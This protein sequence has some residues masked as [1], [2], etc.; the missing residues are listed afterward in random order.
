M[1]NNNRSLSNG[2]QIADI[3][4][5]DLNGRL[6]NNLEESKITPID[7]KKSKEA[8]TTTESKELYIPPTYIPSTEIC[9]PDH[10]LLLKKV[11]ERKD[12][13][14]INI[15]IDSSLSVEEMFQLYNNEYSH[16]LVNGSNAIVRK[17]VNDFGEIDYEY[18]ALEQFRSATR[19]HPKVEINGKK[20]RLADAWLDSE[21]KNFNP[22]GITYDP[23][24]T[25]HKYN[26]FNGWRYEPLQFDPRYIDPWLDHI[27]YIICD[28]DEVAADY[29]IKWFAYMFQHPDKKTISSLVLQSG[30]GCGKGVMVDPIGELMGR[31]Y[32]YCSGEDELM[33]RFNFPTANRK[34]IFLD[35][36]FVGSIAKA[37]K[38]KAKISSERDSIE[39]KGINRAGL[40][41][42]CQYV[43]SGNDQNFLRLDLKQRRYLIIK[44]SHRVQNNHAYFSPLVARKDSPVF[45][46]MLL[47]YFLKVD[48][49]GFNPA[50]IPFSRGNIDEQEDY[51]HTSQQFTL[52]WLARC[53]NQGFG[54]I[55]LVSVEAATAAF[56][57]WCIENNKTTTWATPEQ[58][59]GKKLNPWI[60]DKPRKN[61]SHG[62]TTRRVTYWEMETDINKILD[63]A[64]E[65]FGWDKKVLI[66][67]LESRI[68]LNQ[69]LS[70]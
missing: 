69:P 17:N 33:D 30:E 53:Y 22:H 47:D 16:V 7:S 5:S 13:I 14:H 32:Y 15:M 23:S 60:T 67:K 52:A 42:L 41:N 29:V 46:A 44:P 2:Q 70:A 39:L 24:N 34:L 12:S 55:D 37:N 49:A 38:L 9:L 50:E 18:F 51:L 28:G 6:K 59:L 1:S 61:I 3:N 25:T 65:V 58:E 19:H 26:L 57:K 54:E 11:V 48:L 68:Q 56:K 20:T 10:D 21:S 4:G 62:R 31:N 63:I 8:K 45:R 64:A 40:K 36:V 66:E 27:K 43:L 35:E